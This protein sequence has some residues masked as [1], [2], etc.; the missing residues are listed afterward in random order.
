[1]P[2]E[3][4]KE[5]CTICIEDIDHAKEARIDGCAHKF[6][7]EC[8]H[9]WASKCENTCPNCKVK[10]KKIVYKNVLGED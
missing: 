8:I 4:K 6:C 5:T 10:F 1:M 3:R 7:F 2:E 9:S